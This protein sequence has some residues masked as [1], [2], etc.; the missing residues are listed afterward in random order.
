MVAVDGAVITAPAPSQ[1]LDESLR[2]R[3]SSLRSYVACPRSTVLASDQTTGSIGSSADLGSALHAVVAEILRTLRRQGESQIS[4]QEAV[5]ICR[6]VTAKGP[7]VLS[8]ADYTG[9]NN[10]AGLIDMVLA[11]ADETWQPTRFMAIEE[12]LFADIL[13]PDGEVRTLTGTPDLVIAAPP[14]TAICLD[15]KSGLGKPQ[16]P[17]EVP[18]GD[19]IQGAQY[20]STGGF[21]QLCAYGVLI[22]MR[23]PSVQDV[24]LREK[25]W[26]W[27]KDP[28]REATIGRAD[29][30]HLIPYLGTVMM[31]LDRGR[32]EG[33][34][35][36]FAQPRPGA[37][38]L[39]RC[40]VSSSCPVPQEQRGLGALAA[41]DDADEA[42]RRWVVV[43][44]LDAQLRKALKAHHEETGHCP[45]VGDGTVVRWDG[46]KGAR[47]FGVH[48]PFV[49]EAEADSAAEDAF[50]GQWAAEAARRGLEVPA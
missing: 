23:W 8:A 41:P 50:M 27:S 28:P 40:P 24:I 49:P 48:R 3:Q 20:L 30:E 31:Q 36:E 12:R 26:R 5:E 22:L 13:C 42:A 1:A 19:A 32:R 43:R 46:P 34:G 44:A 38:C 25:S 16:T 11:F 21:F 35:S 33:E 9:H 2:Y 37:H 47:K 45:E 7:W 6:E 17:R 39:T 29:L 14:S 10:R 15:H 18:E 4:T